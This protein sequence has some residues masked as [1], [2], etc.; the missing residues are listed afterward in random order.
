MVSNHHYYEILETAQAA[1]M[2]FANEHL[3]AFANS[4]VIG[5]KSARWI[6][7]LRNRPKKVFGISHKLE[8]DLDRRFCSLTSDLGKYATEK[9]GIYYDFADSPICVSGKDALILGTDRDAIFSLVP[10]RS[11]LLFSHEGRAWECTKT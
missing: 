2:T 4:F 7:L 8:S 9:I 1:D 10:G 11:A 6:D 5:N 3:E